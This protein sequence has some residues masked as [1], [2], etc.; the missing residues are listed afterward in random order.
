MA[1]KQ[2]YI[3]TCGPY[4]ID[5]G[6]PLY[7]DPDQV[8][9]LIDIPPVPR[10]NKITVTNNYTHISSSVVTLCDATSGNLIVTLCSPSS[11]ILFT[12]YIFKKTDAS[13]NIITVNGIDITLQNEIVKFMSDGISWELI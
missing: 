9:K 12:D 1:I 2:F 3:G 7:N 11:A 8:A 10:K 4:L 13:A 6:D 5:D